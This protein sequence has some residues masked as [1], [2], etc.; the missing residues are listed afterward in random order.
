VEGRFLH[1]H[2][3]EKSAVDYLLPFGKETFE[4]IL[5]DYV[6]TWPE[7]KDEWMDK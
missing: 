2:S 4:L 1:T 3:A 7:R 5:W 6:V